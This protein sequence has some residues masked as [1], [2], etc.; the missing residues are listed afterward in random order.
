VPIVLLT[1]ATYAQDYGREANGATA[2]KF[3][4]ADKYRDEQWEAKQAY[5]AGNHQLA[6]RIWTSLADRGDREAQYRLGLL[7][8]GAQSM[9]WYFKAARNGHP[10]A[11]YIIAS[12]YREE[13]NY[14]EAVRWYRRSAQ[15]GNAMSQSMLG[16]MYEF[17]LGVEHDEAKALMWN[18]I[19][20]RTDYNGMK[21]WGTTNIVASKRT[22]IGAAVIQR[23]ERLMATCIASNYTVCD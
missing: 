21:V 1:T 17:G 10:N 23:A 18:E 22:Y 15:A 20:I 2:S 6:A 13:K 8:S 7:Y 3:A 11:Q 4:Q 12:Q 16:H 5:N 9:E 14:A 19:A